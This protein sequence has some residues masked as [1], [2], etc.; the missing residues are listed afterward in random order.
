MELL[1][2]C[3]VPGKGGR[4]QRKL[5]LIM[6]LTAILTLVFTLNLSA[7]TFSQSVLSLIHI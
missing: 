7:K 3:K 1:G 4:M 6:R 5:L 2:T